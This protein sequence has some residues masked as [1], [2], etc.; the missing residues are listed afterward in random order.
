MQPSSMHKDHFVLP[1]LLDYRSW[2][3]HGIW[4]VGQLRWTVG[5][6]VLHKEMLQVV[7]HCGVVWRQ[8]RDGDS[9]LASS[10][11]ST[12]TMRVI[13]GVRAKE[14]FETILRCIA[15]IDDV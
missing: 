14:S 10:A 7:K 5:I 12:D 3:V 2:L 15:E 9:G 13:C 11:C 4:V 8:E 1:F 6:R